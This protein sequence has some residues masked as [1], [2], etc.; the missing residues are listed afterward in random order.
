MPTINKPALNAL[1]TDLLDKAAAD[2]SVK[3]DAK[4]LDQIVSIVGDRWFKSSASIADTLKGGNLLAE[5]KLALAKKGLDGKEKADVAALLDDPQF[6]KL[7]DPVST[8]FLKA[9]I[10][11]ESLKP[12]DAMGP[13]TRVNTVSY[14]A[15]DSEVAAVSKMK[16]LIKGGQLKSYYD[17]ATGAVDNPALKDEALKLFAALPK[18]TVDSID[19]DK[20]V[21]YGLWTTAPR[22]IEEMQK[23]ARYLPGR[24][25]LVDT[26]VHANADDES[27]LLTYQENGTKARTYRAAIAGEEGDNFLVKVDGKD[28]PIKVAKSEIYKLN[29]PH[30]FPGD[31]VNLSGTIDYND[32]FMK[33]KIAEAAVKMDE[34]VGKL[35]FTK[36]ATENASG[37]MT[38]FNRGQSAQ[39][40]VELQR[41]CVRVAHDVINMVYPDGSAERR[42]GC[43]GSGGAGRLAV[44]GSG[45]CYDQATVML[46]VLNP[47]R[48]M[49]GVDVKF[50][51]GGVYRHV[52]GPTDTSF[53]SQAHGWLELT[54]RP[55]METRI[56]DRTWCQ[57]DQTMDKAYS[58]WG[59]RYPSSFYWGVKSADVKPTDVNCS[60]SVSVETFD[61]QFGTRGVDGRDHHMSDFQR[62]NRVDQ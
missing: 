9:L 45:V 3:V 24:Q 46:G 62:N 49:L 56:C 57:P 21:A 23:S 28:D 27:T 11:L 59:D 13:A 6:S 19:A 14:L 41:Q 38:I 58:R 33:A 40:M 34:L 31:T 2:P 10:G 50:I 51:S 61:R 47:F 36:M 4:V 7:L 16:Q 32:P 60:G 17:A 44:N 53:M 52:R 8:N 26:T 37:F 25:V 20:M 29:Q 35:D 42:P 48:E 22:G 1:R 15:P 54:Y 18:I 43:T 30:A 12:V 39:K 5:E 55:S